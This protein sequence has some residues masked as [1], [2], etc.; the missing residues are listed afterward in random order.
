MLFIL[1]YPIQTNKNGDIHLDY[2]LQRRSPV[3]YP[4]SLILRQIFGAIYRQGKTGQ[5]EESC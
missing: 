1:S 4:S 3:R 5:G 2:V